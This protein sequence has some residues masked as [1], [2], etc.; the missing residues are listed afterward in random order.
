MAILLTVA[1]IKIAR[2]HTPEV[3]CTNGTLT[4]SRVFYTLLL[5][6]SLPVC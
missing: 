3:I 5:E 1:L 4:A 2:S 6:H